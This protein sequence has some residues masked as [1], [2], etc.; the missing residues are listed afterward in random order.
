MRAVFAKALVFM[1]T[2]SLE[3]SVHA[4]DLDLQQEPRGCLA[5]KN[6]CAIQNLN[7]RGFEIKIGDA[8]I[9]LDHASSLIRKSNSEI[10]LVGGTAWIKA[11]SSFIVSS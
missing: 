6:V 4:A 7:D 8:V 11:T 2:F 9:T 1:M 5:T 10:R 3:V